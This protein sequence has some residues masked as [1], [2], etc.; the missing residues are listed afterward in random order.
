[1]ELFKINGPPGTG[2]TTR[3][4]RLTEQLIK[5]G[6]VNPDHVY[7]LSFTKAAKLSLLKKFQSFGVEV[8]D[9]NISTLHSFALRELGYSDFFSPYEDEAYIKKFF[10]ERGLFYETLYI[11]DGYDD[12]VVMTGKSKPGNVLYHLITLKRLQLGDEKWIYDYIH[13]LPPFWTP[14]NFNCLYDEFMYYMDYIGICDFTKLLEEYSLKEPRLEGDVLIVDEAQDLCPLQMKIL[15]KLFPRF[16]YVIVAGD[17]DQCIF[18]W[19]G[20]DPTLMLN[21][22]PTE[23]INLDQSYRLPK[24]ICELAKFIIEKNS[25]REPI[26]YKP[27][28]REGTVGRISMQEFK[29]L[30]GNLSANEKVF[31]L[32]RH[33]YVL[34]EYRQILRKLGIDAFNISESN[35]R[36]SGVFL[37]TIHRAKGLEAETVFLDLRVN[38]KVS[39]HIRK[40]GPDSERRVL[41]VGVT[42]AKERLFLLKW[43]ESSA[44]HYARFMNGYL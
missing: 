9:K 36:D 18:E 42:R 29:T 16:K 3:I 24:T 37:G 11:N 5:E 28:N 22:E 38:D 35:E 30:V 2:K 33:T 41:Y 19:A 31:I 15:K 32:A 39:D 34:S 12:S 7:A 44:L 14:D 4:C 17:V 27:T 6:R 20:A 25:D 23:K 26:D 8:R 10:N 13:I 40:K 1:M 21:L 43:N